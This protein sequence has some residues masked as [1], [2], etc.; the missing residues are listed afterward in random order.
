VTGRSRRIATEWQTGYQGLA[1]RLF[2]QA[3]AT[4][5]AESVEKLDR[6]LERLHD[7][8]SS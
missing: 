2:G 6:V 5:V 4:K 3:G 1:E 7:E 8:E